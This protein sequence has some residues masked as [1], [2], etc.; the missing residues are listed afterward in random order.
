MVSGW[1][2][3][4][5]EETVCSRE[6]GDRGGGDEGVMTVAMVHAESLSGRLLSQKVESEARSQL[7]LRGLRGASLVA[8]WKSRRRVSWS[9]AHVHSRAWGGRR[10]RGS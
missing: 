8:F 10:V 3:D 2:S 4:I 7:R 6:G 1:E 5:R 9:G